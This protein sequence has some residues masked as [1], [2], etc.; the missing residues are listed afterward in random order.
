MIS[1]KVYINKVLHLFELVRVRT[2]EKVVYLTFDDGPDGEITDFVISELE[3][4]NAKATF[5]CKGENVCKNN[6]QFKKL[7]TLG[8]SVGNHT[9]S[10]KNCFSVQTKEYL[11]DVKKA[12]SYIDSVLFRPPHGS[13]T[14]KVFLSLY[15]HYKIVHW[16]LMSGDTELGTLNL[17]V[18]LE[19]LKN[20]TRPGEIVLF[21]SCKLHESETRLILPP[22][23]EWLYAVGYKCVR[24]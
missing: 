4:Y 1:A 24:L 11:A 2:K 21:H 12:S 16:S 3:K 15:R 23:L 6:A 5:F 14:L 18:T 22:Y 7:V 19:R 9:Y 8:H 13:L 17:E 20:N 10:H